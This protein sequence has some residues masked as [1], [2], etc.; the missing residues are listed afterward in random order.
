MERLVWR[1][2]LLSVF[3][4]SG[5]FCRSGHAGREGRPFKR[6]FYLGDAPAAILPDY[7]SD[8]PAPIVLPSGVVPDAGVVPPVGAIAPAPLIAPAPAILP[9]NAIKEKNR[10][11]P[12]AEGC[13]F[14]QFIYQIFHL[15][16]HTH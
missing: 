3:L 7:N 14:I 10:A 16:F 6:Q 1:V 13:H 4:A 9:S 8:M 2:T 15:I 5:V 11:Y 12:T